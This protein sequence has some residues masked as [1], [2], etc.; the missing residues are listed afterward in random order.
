MQEEDV[1]YQV[2]SESDG[3]ENPNP[4]L[5]DSIYQAEAEDA[6]FIMEK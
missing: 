1:K 3:N 2:S 5:E 6:E 4:R